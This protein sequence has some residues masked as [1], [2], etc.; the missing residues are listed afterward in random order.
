MKENKQKR[1]WG[2]GAFS[3]FEMFIYSLMGLFS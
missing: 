3:L 2:Y 1:G